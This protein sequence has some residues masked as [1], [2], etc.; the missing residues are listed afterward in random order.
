[1]SVQPSVWK[2]SFINKILHYHE[3]IFKMR[4]VANNGIQI[5]HFK[6]LGVSGG[7]S[8]S[9]QI[10][11]SWFWLRAFFELRQKTLNALLIYIISERKVL[12]LCASS[13]RNN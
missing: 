3:G 4:P 5:A 12:T 1:M 13:K 7:Q 2:T 8:A 10:A 11:H 6:L 9:D